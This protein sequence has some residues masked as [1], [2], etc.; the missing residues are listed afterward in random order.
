[1][2]NQFDTRII[3]QSLS[4]LSLSSES[5]YRAGGCMSNQSGA[6][7][8]RAIVL[9]ASLSTLSLCSPAQ[10]SGSPVASADGDHSV[11]QLESQ[12]RELRAVLDEI[13]AESAQSRAEMRELRQELE[14]TRKLLVPLI[15]STNPSA[16]NPQEAAPHSENSAGAISGSQST[17]SGATDA[18]LGNRVQ[19]LEESTQLLGSK[20]NEQYQTKVETAGKYRAR[21]SGIVL[22]NAFRNV[23]GSDNLDL[24]DYAQPVPWG[25]SQSSFGA[26]LRQTEIG[27]EIF[28]PNLAGAKTTGNV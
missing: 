17:V 6:G 28:G 5:E 24:P 25:S 12:V 7:L 2:P 9:A 15:A 8:L 13:R 1:M 27:L 16:L 23:G 11:Q 26:T 19:K 22:M 10:E 21:L 14:S 20:V 18:D 3:F 4:R